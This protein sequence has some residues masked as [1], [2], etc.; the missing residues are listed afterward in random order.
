MSGKMDCCLVLL[1]PI[2][3]THTT[4]Y[5]P[6]YFMEPTAVMNPEVIDHLELDPCK[7]WFC[8]KERFNYQANTTRAL[9]AKLEFVDE[10]F[11]RMAWEW[12]N[13]SVPGEDR[14]AYYQKI[15]SQC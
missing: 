9:A 14:T 13:P 2:G 15:C 3:L 6:R 11:Y 4:A 1:L 12:N 5:L 7:R 8:S 10:T